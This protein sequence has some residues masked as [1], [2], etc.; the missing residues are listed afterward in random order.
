MFA[1]KNRIYSLEHCG[2]CVATIK[3]GGCGGE[4]AVYECRVC[5]KNFIQVSGG[6]AQTPLI[7]EELDALKGGARL[8][9]EEG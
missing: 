3:S 4:G 8:K 1:P 9:K 7:L 2:F 5:K 6:L